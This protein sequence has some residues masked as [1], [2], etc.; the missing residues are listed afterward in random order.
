MLV[1]RIG[2]CEALTIVSTSI[3]NRIALIT[4]ELPRAPPGAMINS[5]FLPL[6]F[7]RACFTLFSFYM[8][9]V[10]QSETTA[11]LPLLAHSTKQHEDFSRTVINIA[12]VPGT[13]KNL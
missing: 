7:R 5:S 11:L 3:G 4:E 12:S 9:I 2:T 13:L 1:G 10:S 6:A 8:H